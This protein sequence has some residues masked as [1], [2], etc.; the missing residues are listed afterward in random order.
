MKL[1]SIL[2]YSVVPDLWA[3]INIASTFKNNAL[4]GSEYTLCT[5][6]PII[7]MTLLPSME[8]VGPDGTV[9]SECRDENVTVGEMEIEG[10][11][12]TLSLLPSCPLITR[13]IL[14][15]QGNC[16]CSMDGGPARSN[17]C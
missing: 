2:N 4:Y 14:H 17:L 10:R 15:M 13:R 12:Y 9:F 16:Q 8:W 11:V 6:R 5:V 1:K 7:G 3:D